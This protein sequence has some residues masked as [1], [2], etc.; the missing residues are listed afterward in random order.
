MSLLTNDYNCRHTCVEAVGDDVCEGVGGA[1]GA[2]AAVGVGHQHVALQVAAL[3]GVGGAAAKHRVVSHVMLNVEGELK[4]NFS[5][6]N[7][8][9][10]A[11]RK[12]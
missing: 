3:L 11:R 5:G 9:D 8:R 10:L 2:G 12:C 1:E 4:Q 6:H 7:I